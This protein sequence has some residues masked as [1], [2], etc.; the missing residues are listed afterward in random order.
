MD[1]FATAAIAT[2][3]ADAAG[4]LRFAERIVACDGRRFDILG[5]HPILSFPQFPTRLGNG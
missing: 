3:E 2:G 1:V 5:R 4:A